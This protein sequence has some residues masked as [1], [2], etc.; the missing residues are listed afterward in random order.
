MTGSISLIGDFPERINIVSASSTF[1]SIQYKSVFKGIFF[2]ALNRT[3]VL[4][5]FSFL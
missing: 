1:E 3:Q 4:Y 5:C 2:F